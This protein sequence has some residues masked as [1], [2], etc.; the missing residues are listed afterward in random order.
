MASLPTPC[1]HTDRSPINVPVV[2]NPFFQSI[3]RIPVV[4]TA[5]PPTSITQM[6]EFGS[7][8]VVSSHCFSISIDGGFCSARKR[9]VSRSSN[10]PIMASASS[11]L[12]GRRRTSFP[13]ITG[14]YMARK[15]RQRIPHVWPQP[16]LRTVLI[17]HVWPQRAPTGPGL[18][19]RVELGRF[20]YIHGNSRALSRGQVER[21][22]VLALRGC[23]LVADQRVDQG[24]QVLVQLLRVEGHL[25]DRGVDD[26][27]LVGPELD[28]A[29]L[30]LAHRSSDI[31][32]HRARLRVRHQ[33]ARSQ[34]LAEG[35]DL[36]H[37]VRRRDSGVEIGPALG[38]LLHE[39]I[40]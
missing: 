37:H 6:T 10:Q 12:G 38:D 19:R 13:W 27:E 20:L 39:I 7:L 31:H 2:P 35:S 17:P 18:A 28:L 3:S 21:A 30:H 9:V 4:P 34:H 11:A 33:S 8:A 16:D 22:E 14:P 36:G 1:P 23:R 32:R 29:A 15:C 5:T 25:A 40:A 24:G 26:A